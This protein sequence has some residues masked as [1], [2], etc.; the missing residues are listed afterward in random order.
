MDNT[1]LNLCFGE[2][3]VDG[4]DKPG[5]AVYRHDQDVLNPTI[6]QTVQNGKPVF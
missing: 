2:C 4:L 1:A 5:K 6:S 3:Y